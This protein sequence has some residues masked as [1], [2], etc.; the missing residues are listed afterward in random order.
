[1][2]ADTVTSW[3]ASPEKLEDMKDAA[4]V[5]ARPSATLDIA[6]DLGEMVFATKKTAVAA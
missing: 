1:M 6:R 3:L 2:I 4:L 5:A